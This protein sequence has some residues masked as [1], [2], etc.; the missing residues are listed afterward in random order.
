MVVLLEG[1]TT[2]QNDDDDDDD[3]DDAWYPS[4]RRGVDEREAEEEEDD[5]DESHKIDGTTCIDTG[6][7]ERA[8]FMKEDQKRDR[9]AFFGGEEREDVERTRTTRRKFWIPS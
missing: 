9:D 6:T 1:T 2:R 3:D 8:A 5:D 4:C 7:A